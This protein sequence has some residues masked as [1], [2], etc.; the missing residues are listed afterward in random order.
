MSI[1]DL[2]E[3]IG[4]LIGKDDLKGAIS[5]L[6][7]LLKSSPKLDA[8]ILQ[9]GRLNDITNQIR[10]GT[11]DFE[12]A[13]ILKNKIRL[14]LLNL[15]EEIEETSGKY[16]DIKKEIENNLAYPGTGQFVQNHSGTGD[17]VMNF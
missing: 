15:I 4:E 3:H 14:A 5:M 11:V 9:S 2:S 17:N 13:D 12:K 1:K 16:P 10:L 8:V 7:D 6:S